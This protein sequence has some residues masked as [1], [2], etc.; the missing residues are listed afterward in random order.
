[1]AGGSCSPRRDQQSAPPLAA[2]GEPLTKHRQVVR[3]SKPVIARQERRRRAASR[4]PT[5]L[6]PTSW[7]PFLQS[8]RPSPD[9]QVHLPPILA[10]PS[11]FLL[12][13][14]PFVV[15]LSPLHS[16]ILLIS[17]PRPTLSDGRGRRRPLMQQYRTF[18]YRS[19]PASS[20]LD[21]IRI[22][23]R[24]SFGPNF[25]PRR[26]AATP[27]P[28]KASPSSALTFCPLLRLEALA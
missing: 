26:D 1:M 23:D 25:L 11:S 28:T 24:P 8:H 27:S 16:P 15:C 13:P 9:L 5:A 3:H 14:P 10:D 20:A 4:S 7:R 12:F 6:H 21:S 18:G 2:A 19:C 22:A 17:P